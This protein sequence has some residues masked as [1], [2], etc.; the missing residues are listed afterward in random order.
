LID[1]LPFISRIIH[2]SENHHTKFGEYKGISKTVTKKVKLKY[3]PKEG[4]HDPVVN[5]FRHA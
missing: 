4:R 1:G 2:L 3:E 5:V